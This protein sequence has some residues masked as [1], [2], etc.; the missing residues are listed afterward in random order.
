L[1]QVGINIDKPYNNDFNNVSPRLGI[2]WDV[3]GTGRTVV[4]AGGSIIYEMPHLAVF[5]GQNGTNNAVTPGLNVV[6][7]GVPG[8]NIPGTIVA[9]GTNTDTLN[10]SLAG[11]VFNVTPDC[12][13]S[14]CD[15]F[16]AQKSLRTPYVMTYNVN[17]QQAFSNSTSIQVAYVANLGRKLYSIRD[18]NQVN[19]NSPAEDPVLGC[20]H[21]EQDG[22]PFATQFPFLAFINFLENGYN[23]NYHGLQ[24][25]LTQRLW[26]GLSFVAGYTWAHSLDQASLNRSQQP[27]NSF[28][29]AGER[30]NSDLDIRHRFT[31]GLSYDLPGREGVGQLLK[32]WQINSIVTVSTGT[33]FNVVDGFIN[34]NDISL[35][36]EFSDRWNFFG[37]PRAFDARI[38]TSIPFIA[39]G[40]TNPACAAVG[41]PTTLASFGCFAVPGAVMVPPALGTFGTMARNIFRGPGIQN[42][43]FSI[44]KNWQ[45]E[46][47]GVQLRAEFFNVLNHPNFANPN[48]SV[49]GFVDPSDPGTFG[50]AC[51]TPDVGG[52]NP[53]IGTG[54]Q[55]NIQLGVKFRF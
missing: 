55:R 54:G 19:P 13:A 35:T 43:D 30:G 49:L 42:W 48:A 18:I 41:D 36:G 37:D 39:D 32:G 2:A 46:R 23:S 25:T 45:A 38:G 15:T 4:R 50:C 11:P 28:N 5:L 12:V 7:T 22:R 29:L 8:S 17:V 40:T 33:P 52:A 16:G 9:T 44:V 26:E 14:P 27:Q 6:P 51:A 20:D 34:G 53:V 31:L 10:W 24:T 3:F 47:L 1:Q 21:C